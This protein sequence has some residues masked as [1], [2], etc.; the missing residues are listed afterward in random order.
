MKIYQLT[1]CIHCV[2]DWE[3]DMDLELEWD[4]NVIDTKFGINDI[5]VTHLAAKNDRVEIIFNKYNLARYK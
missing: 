4:E 1:I 3:E 5:T 2:V